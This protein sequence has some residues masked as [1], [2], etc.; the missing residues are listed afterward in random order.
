MD[1]II[2]IGEFVFFGLMQ[3]VGVCS[4]CIKEYVIKIVV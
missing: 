3:V 2:Y 1:N 4:I